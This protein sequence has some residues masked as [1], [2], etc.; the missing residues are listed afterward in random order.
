MVTNSQPHCTLLINDDHLEIFS[1]IWLDAYINAQRNQN[2]QGR[3]RAR[4]SRIK[5]FR[6]TEEQK[7]CIEQTPEDDQLVLMV[8]GQLD[9]Q[10]ISSVDQ[11]QQVSRIDIDSEDKGGD[12]KWACEFTK[13]S[14]L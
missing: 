1:R 5:N 3:L 2:T 10:F 14:F 8:T 9:R 6:D 11:L 13:V 12:G 7:N 4:I